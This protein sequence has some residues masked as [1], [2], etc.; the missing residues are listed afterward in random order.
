MAERNKTNWQPDPASH[1][2]LV[3]NIVSLH[4]TETYYTLKPSA[5]IFLSIIE[6][7]MKIRAVGTFRV[8]REQ[9]DAAGDFIL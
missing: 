8:Y 9:T 4:K 5:G 6:N 7:C 2:I 3:T 1:G